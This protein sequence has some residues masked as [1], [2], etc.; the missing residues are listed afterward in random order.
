MAR[1]LHG[2]KQPTFHIRQRMGHASLRNANRGVL[3]ELWGKPEDPTAVFVD[4]PISRAEWTARDLRAAA[5][6]FEEVATIL[7]EAIQN[8]KA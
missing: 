3:L 4:A 5:Q 8:G 6:L 7:E 2:A 1:D